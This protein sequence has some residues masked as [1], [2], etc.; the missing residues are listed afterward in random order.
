GS[1]SEPNFNENTIGNCQTPVIKNGTLD[2]T[3]TD[4]AEDAAFSNFDPYEYMRWNWDVISKGY[5]FVFFNKQG[6]MFAGRDHSD[7]SVN[8]LPVVGYSVQ[9]LRAIDVLGEVDTDDV[10]HNL[11]VTHKFTGTYYSV[12]PVPTGILEVVSDDLHAQVS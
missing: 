10:S 5:V 9:T 12:K 4:F 2:F 6:D 8:P 3:T 7:M 1:V 11:T